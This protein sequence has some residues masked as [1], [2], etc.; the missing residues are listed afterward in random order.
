MNILIDNK[1]IENFT[2]TNESVNVLSYKELEEVHDGIYL[3]KT[4]NN[5]TFLKEAKTTW[6]SKPVVEFNV[7]AQDRLFKNVQF[8][9]DP[10]SKTSLNFNKLGINSV[11]AEKTTQPTRLLTDTNVDI[12]TNKLN[13]KLE[14]S[15]KIA[16]K[17][18]AD[19]TAQQQDHIEEFVASE[20]TKWMEQ[21]VGDVIVEVASVREK[22]QQDLEALKHQVLIEGS[23]KFDELEQDLDAAGE[24]VISNIKQHGQSTADTIVE[25]LQEYGKLVE[26]NIQSR[27]IVVEQAIERSVRSSIESVV[28]D[29][30]KEALA[31]TESN[32][33][34]IGLYEKFSKPIIKQ[35]LERL[36]S[37]AESAQGRVNAVIQEA[38]NKA[39][40]IDGIS[41]EIEN[42]KYRIARVAE[43]GGG[44]VAV[45]YANGGVMNG[46]LEITGDLVVGGSF[47]GS[48]SLSSLAQTG[49]SNG[50]AIIWSDALASWTPGDATIKRVYYVGDG[51]SNSFTINH[52]LSSLDLMHQVYDNN[53]Q[54]VVVPY[55][56]NT[57]A[58]NTQI[59][60]SFVPSPS[61]YRMII[62]K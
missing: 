26:Q 39:N 44:T 46:S 4:H 59:T 7:L 18:I 62:V 6:K 20:S 3:I 30:T 1:E 10:R 29:H 32:D 24:Q 61:A 43:S 33:L 51:V 12:Y 8:V 35:V 14:E 36:N 50:Q 40:T 47:T 49:A 45:Q 48:T 42:L 57:D 37:A 28:I 16:K 9:L 58:Q 41:K 27:A 56:K 21:I 31:H 25:S 54:E 23:I 34:I 60:F 55:I 5:Q 15:V 19:V 17:H 52:Q 53:T 13:Q 38:Q 2:N 11:F 22:M